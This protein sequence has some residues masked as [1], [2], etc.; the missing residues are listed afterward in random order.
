MQISKV[1]ISCQSSV[2]QT[3]QALVVAELPRQSRLNRNS[4]IDLKKVFGLNN[5]QGCFNQS[6]NALSFPR[7]SWSVWPPHLSLKLKNTLA[8]VHQKG[9]RDNFSVNNQVS[10]FLL[11]S[12]CWNSVCL[13]KLF[14]R[15]YKNQSVKVQNKNDQ[16]LPACPSKGPSPLSERVPI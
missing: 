15:R 3:C 2:G 7:N 6:I 5:R 13:R 10:T 8:Q 16:Y 9:K 14:Q 4:S 12:C 11:H 1:R